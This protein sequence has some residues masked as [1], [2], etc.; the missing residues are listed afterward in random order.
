MSP[1]IHSAWNTSVDFIR[2]VCCLCYFLQIQ[3]KRLING[4]LWQAVRGW[5]CPF[6]TT[7][8][9]A[10]QISTKDSSTSVANQ[11]TEPE[12]HVSHTTVSLL[13][14]VTEGWTSFRKLNSADLSGT[15]LFWKK[16]LHIFF[17]YAHLFH[18][19]SP[20]LVCFEVLPYALTLVYTLVSGLSQSPLPSTAWEP[21][22]RKL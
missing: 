22:L 6:R 2:K 14:L 16:T 5:S 4:K 21:F 7:T 1:V 9:S 20:G 19:Y 15:M 13:S 11:P 12:T 17:S 8:S 18:G 3:V 10:K